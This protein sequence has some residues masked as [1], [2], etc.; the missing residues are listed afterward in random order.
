[1]ALP[2]LVAGCAA[3]GDAPQTLR[4]AIETAKDRKAAP[5]FVLKDSSGK[6][7]NLAKYRGKIVLLDFWATWCHGCKEEIPWFAEFERKY[8][9]KGF[10]VVGVSLDDDGWAVVRPF[11]EAAKVPY[12]MLLGDDPTAKKYS[13]E[14]MPDTFIID[15]KGRIAA[16]Y[17]GLVDRGDVEANIETMLRER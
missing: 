3:A 17:V 15:R 13:I 2:M 9:S 5:E 10:A 11:L 16:K 12:R 4:A 14:A 6:T 8:G 7:V 1:L